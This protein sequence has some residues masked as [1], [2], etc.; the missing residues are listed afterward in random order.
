MKKYQLGKN[1][2]VGIKP[3]IIIERDL[4]SKEALH[5]FEEL[6]ERVTT[7]PEK[8]SYDVMVRYC[9]SNDPTATLTI[10]VIL[11]VEF[12]KHAFMPGKLVHTNELMVHLGD[13]YFASVTC[14]QVMYGVL[15]KY[16]SVC[17]GFLS[18]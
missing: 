14:Q 4:F 6:S 7:L 2:C 13:A 11:Q 17:L 1:I 8:L 15:A 12:G 9:C 5:S 16:S 10:L 18:A 3:D